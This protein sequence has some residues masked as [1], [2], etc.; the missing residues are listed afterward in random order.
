MTNPGE[1]RK[2]QPPF[3]TLR[4]F[5]AVGRLCGIRRAAQTLHIDHAVIS[6]HL[7]ALEDWA[8]VRLFDRARSST[9]LTPEGQRY[10]VRVAAALAEISDAGRE[11]LGRSSD[12][13][14][15]IWC[16][17]GFASEWLMAR[18]QM[19]Q[20]ENPE[21]ELELHP[22]DTSPD[23][24]RY[25]A[26]VDIRY[27][28]GARTVSSA[29]ISEGLRR[30]E[31]ARPPVVAVAS[32]K[33]ITTLPLISQPKDLLGAPLLH[34]D[35]HRQWQCWLSAYEV[36]VPDELP[37]PRL[38]HAHLTVEAARRGQGIALA[39]PFLLGDDLVT[40]RLIDVLGGLSKSIALGT[41]VFTAR[42]DRWQS[43]AVVRFRHW[44][45]RATAGISPPAAE[46]GPGELALVRSS[47]RERTVPAAARG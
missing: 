9:V 20:M 26:D 19:F 11:L 33:R 45:K 22:T 38:W 2:A 25:E 43:P 16:V 42:A 29:T 47:R 7:R 36:I 13:H 35:N 4:A 21:I 3:A 37:G 46:N 40:G 1:D 18:L 44:L 39:N 41:Y 28:S 32:L 24:T 14:L 34:E 27:V 31:I 17:P 6:R 30:F 12:R 15:R 5:E 23:F 10:H 8:G